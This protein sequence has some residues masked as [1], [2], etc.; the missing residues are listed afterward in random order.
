MSYPQASSDIGAHPEL[1]E[2]RE[3]L[4][5][6]ASSGQAV[7]IEGLIVL[8]GVYAAISPWVVHFTN[9]P[10][11]TVNNLIVGITVGVLGLGLTLA[12]DRMFRLAWVAAPLGVWLLLSP[13]VVTAAHSA[14]AGIIWSNCWTGAVITVLGLAAAGLT[15]G[16][17]RRSSSR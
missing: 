17:N 12:P 16:V 5:R 1:A 11:I 9:E 4:E 2:M 15:L 10:N 7:A 13:W 3:R 14:R 6:T 8:A